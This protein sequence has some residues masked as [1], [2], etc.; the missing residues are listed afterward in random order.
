MFRHV[1]VIGRT[2]DREIERDLHPASSNFALP[3]RRNPPASRARAQCPCARHRSATR[4]RCRWHKARP[5]RHGSRDNRIVSSFAVG[6]TDRMNRR[7]IDH[8]ESHR[9]GIIDPR[10]TIAQRRTA[11]AATLGGAREKFVPSRSPR[12]QRSTTTRG[13]GAH[14]VAP[15]RSG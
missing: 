12:F 9:F 1:G 8:V 6:G 11:I 4:C 14:C 10:Q 7:E 3:A 13:G 5:V 2:V 15:V